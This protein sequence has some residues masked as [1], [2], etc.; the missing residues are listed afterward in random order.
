M[1]YTYLVIVTYYVTREQSKHNFGPYLASE[2]QQQSPAN[3]FQISLSR[4]KYR[5]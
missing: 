3:T 4:L 5:N 2:N 1:I